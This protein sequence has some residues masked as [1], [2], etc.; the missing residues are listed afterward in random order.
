MSNK[1]TYK[2]G[3]INFPVKFEAVRKRQGIYINNTNV[4]NV[5]LL[6]IRDKF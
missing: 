6:I 3:S 2:A 4:D 5:F 1:D